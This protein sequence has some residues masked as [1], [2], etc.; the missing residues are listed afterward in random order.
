MGGEVFVKKYAT[1]FREDLEWQRKVLS[2][3]RV[4][5]CEI[6]M[7][8]YKGKAA[9]WQLGTMIMKIPKEYDAFMASLP[10]QQS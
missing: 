6:E 9:H 3:L 2:A 5:S 4:R 8:W 1:K 10:V 7:N